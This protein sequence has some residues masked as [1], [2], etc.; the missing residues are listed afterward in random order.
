M[1]ATVTAYD[2]SP[3]MLACHTNNSEQ[4]QALLEKNENANACDS[5]NR[6]ALFYCSENTDT[7]CI[8]LLHKKA[9]LNLNHQDKDGYSCMHVAVM[10]GN[11]AIVEYLIKSGADV[12]ITDLE[13]HSVVHW[14]VVCGQLS[15]FEFLIANNADP[16]TA[17]IHGAYPI[18]YAAQMCGKIDSLD[19]SVQRDSSKS[20]QILK[21]LIEQKVKVDVEDFD[22]RN[23]IIW[24]ASSGSSEAITELF[25]AG[26]DPN[27]H[28]KDGLTGN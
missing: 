4:V 17:D 11:F 12:N 2:V 26:S 28:E 25:K 13:M 10:C 8:Q 21:K 22:Q 27:K 16:E 6:T 1:A 19:S 7:S 9:K 3:L 5:S 18:H 14:S 20:V 24:A 15:L 23:A